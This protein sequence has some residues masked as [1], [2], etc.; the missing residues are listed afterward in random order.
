ME[1]ELQKFDLPFAGGGQK[2]SLDRRSN[3]DITNTQFLVIVNYVNAPK[4][5]TYRGKEKLEKSF[6]FLTTPL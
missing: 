3:K 6:L 2:A 4:T 5:S 1:D